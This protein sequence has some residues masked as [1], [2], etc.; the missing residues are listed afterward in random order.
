[1]FSLFL[2]LFVIPAMYSFLSSK[3]KKSEIDNF[4]HP[5]TTTADTKIEPSA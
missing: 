5:E 1:M 4:I 3:K 2:T